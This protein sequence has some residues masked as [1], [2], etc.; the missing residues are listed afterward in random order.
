MT[1]AELIQGFQPAY[2]CPGVPYHRIK[3]N[4]SSLPWPTGAQNAG[5]KHGVRFA[6]ND[7]LISL[8]EH[9]LYIGQCAARRVKRYKC[10]IH[11][12]GRLFTCPVRI[13]VRARSHELRSFLAEFLQPKIAV[14][15]QPARVTRRHV[16]GSSTVSDDR[17]HH[18]ERIRLQRGVAEA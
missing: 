14:V 16:A 4:Y 7:I 2:M 15:E 3:A 5:E 6:Q 12:I 11:E 8:S 10:V 17:V 18:R 1:D 13:T 9:L